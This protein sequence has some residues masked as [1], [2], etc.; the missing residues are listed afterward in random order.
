MALWTPMRQMAKSCM[1]SWPEPRAHAAMSMMMISADL[2]HCMTERLLQRSASQP[3]NM[4]KRM[5]GSAKAAPALAE[6]A[7]SLSW[8]SW[9]ARTR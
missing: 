4:L 9:R 1:V 8:P 6:R 2:T 7:T 5:K 3:P